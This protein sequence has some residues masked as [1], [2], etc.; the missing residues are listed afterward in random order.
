[1][2]WEAL[3]VGKHLCLFCSQGKEAVMVTQGVK[4]GLWRAGKCDSVVSRK[5]EMGESGKECRSE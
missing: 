3:V 5:D 1:M 4:K 2:A